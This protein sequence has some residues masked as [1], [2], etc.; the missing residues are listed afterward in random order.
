[1]LELNGSDQIN[2]YPIPVSNMLTIKSSKEVLSVKLTGVT[3]EIIYNRAGINASEFLIDMS[4]YSA[5]VY[6]LNITSK[7]N[8]GEPII[9]KI[10]K[11]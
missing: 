1:L 2:I 3:G 9:R 10:L 11:K 6:I 8:P 4:K 7:N 5:G